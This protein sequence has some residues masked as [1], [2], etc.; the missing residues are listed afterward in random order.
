MT[1]RVKTATIWPLMGIHAQDTK[2]AGAWRLYVLASTL[3]HEH[4]EHIYGKCNGGSGK[5]ERAK[6]QEAAEALGVKRSTFYT[7]LAD[8]RTAKILNGEGEYLYLAS[9]EKLS[10]I[11]LCNQIDE[12][13]ATIPI[14]LLFKAGWKDVVFAAYL[15][16]NHHTKIGLNAKM[17]PMYKGNL[18]SAQTIEDITGIKPRTQRR[19]KSL[20]RTQKNIA[21]TSIRGDWE[22]AKRLNQAARDHGEHRHYFVFN[23]P[24]QKDPAGIK[25][26]RRVIAHTKPARRTVSD[27]HAA[28]GARGRRKQIALAISKGLRLV[29]VCNYPFIEAQPLL[30]QANGKPSNSETF[31]Q[32]RR[33]YMETPA[34]RE[35]ILKDPIHEAAQ[36]A[37]VLRYRR[38]NVG[39]WDRVDI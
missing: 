9:Q 39:V 34:Q 1:P 17:Q 26:Y 27:K 10:Q 19:Y 5:I 29:N 20:V 3:D 38:G 30:Q 31:T 25:N 36:E 33:L 22:T 8:A 24:N 11:F 18:I 21:I 15:K 35:L 12:H 2:H 37:Y 14:K 6:L 28:V 32:Y 23:D 16:V 4:C 13:K 7:W